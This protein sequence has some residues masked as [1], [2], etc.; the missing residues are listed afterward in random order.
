MTQYL[1]KALD[2]GS[3]TTWFLRGKLHILDFLKKNSLQFLEM[4][5]RNIN[6]NAFNNKI[7]RGINFWGIQIEGKESSMDKLASNWLDVDL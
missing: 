2:N 4:E 5:N 7:P 6:D 1:Q 3:Q